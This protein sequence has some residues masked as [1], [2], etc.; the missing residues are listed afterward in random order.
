MLF[1]SAVN[2][3]SS[4][5]GNNAEVDGA[6][7]YSLIAGGRSNMTFTVSY[8]SGVR[9]V[10]RRPPTGKLLPSAHDMAREYRL[11]H[12]LRSSEVPVP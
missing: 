7:T 10:L 4:W 12:S 6:I 9:F 5:I 1:R 11:M 2:K 3:V 8:N